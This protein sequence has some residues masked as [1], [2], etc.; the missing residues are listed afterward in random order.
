M[1]RGLRIQFHLY[2]ETRFG[3]EVYME[4]ADGLLPLHYTAGHIWRGS[5]EFPEHRPVRYRYVRREDTGAPGQAEGGGWRLFI[6]PHFAGKAEVLLIDQW[7]PVDDWDHMLISAPFENT[8]FRRDP[9]FSVTAGARYS[10]RLQVAAPRVPPGG[11]LAIVGETPE[12]GAWSPHRALP[13]SAGPFPW[14]FI[15]LPADIG[16]QTFLYKF[17]AVEK[18]NPYWEKGE[19]RLFDLKTTG[20]TSHGNDVT[21]YTVSPFRHG[22]GPWRGTGVT[23]PLFSLRTNRSMGTG[24]FPDLKLFVDWSEK[25]GMNMIQ[26]L[27]INDTTAT[28]TWH[29]SYPYGVI[30]VFALHPLYLSIRDLV[31]PHDALAREIETATREL[32]RKD[33]LDYE[34]VMKTKREFM[35]SIFTA[36]GNED[37]STE[38]FRLFFTA[39]EEWL[40][41]YG[42]FSHL[43]DLYGTVDFR[44]W[45]PHR[46]PA[47]EIVAE[48]SDPTSPHYPQVAFHYFVQYHLH[49]QLAEAAQYAREHRV[50]LKGDIPIGVAPY[51]VETWL[52]PEWFDMDYRVGAPPDAFSREG[53]NWG[54]PVYRW[55]AMEKDG[56]S[57]WQ[58][59]LSHLAR[60]FDAVRLDHVIGF[61]R[62][63]RIP[64]EAVTARC[65]H[66]HP[67]RGYTEK[68][69][70]E[71][72]I[73][74][75]ERLFTPYL[76]DEVLQVFSPSTSEALK[77][78]FFE[79]AS[80]GVYRLREEYGSQRSFVAACVKRFGLDEGRTKRLLAIHD[81]VVLIPEKAGDKVFY[82]PAIAM[83]D[84]FSFRNLPEMVQNALRQ[85]S[86]E[87]FGNRQEDL[88]EG[89]AIKKLGALREAT[90]MLLCAEDLGMVPRCIPSVLEKLGILGLRIQRMP[91]DAGMLYDDPAAYS[92]LT[93]ASPSNHDMPTIR[94]WWVE[95]D[96]AVI[97]MYYEHFLK[98]KGVAPRF[99]EPWICRAIIDRHLQSPSMWVLLPIQDLLGMSGDLR[100]EEVQAERI[101][102][103]ADPHHRWQFRLHLT[104]E[105]LLDHHTFADEFRKM[106]HR[107]GR[108]GD[109]QT[110]FPR[111]GSVINK[112]I[113]GGGHGNG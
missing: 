85:L 32:N 100:R 95:T 80:P 65:G 18:T 47:W 81:E 82:H 79:T 91:P 53:Q 98:G 55:Q 23:V 68:E 83:E 52:H 43:R 111:E 54:F 22:Q 30:S 89:E 108:A 64:A 78:D 106:L 36:R 112:D 77:V 59:R 39:N 17:L 37:L 13:M 72:G 109:G 19:N 8:I 88:W 26:L 93:V 4:H 1:I 27:P 84:T 63:W 46:S 62:I 102:N 5:G 29:D 61:A 104:V 58:K 60:Y 31:S 103:P 67:A 10:L 3:E 20:V 7:H 86:R 49:R 66:F 99:C 56:F 76:T 34:A 92:Y 33:F 87:Y 74:D 94:G 57:W 107:S 105:E 15:D 42:V 12:M 69:L 70:E 25:M 16:H 9:P 113:K 97:Q 50:A 38:Q 73:T 2:C 24:E 45:G 11:H 21:V 101:N 28:L 51:S 44:H 48:M 90:D 40:R 71:R 75:L 41:P 96:R 14:W 6:P 35:M 110:P